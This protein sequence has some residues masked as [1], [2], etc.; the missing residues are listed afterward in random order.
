MRNAVAS[1]DSAQPVF[2]F[3]TMEERVEETW[4]T[5][6]LLTSLLTLFA[7]L[8]CILAVVGI[9]GVISYNGLRR[10]R[11]IGVRLALGARRQQI[12]TLI[13]GQGLRLLLIGLFVGFA[14]AFALS[15]VMRSVLFGVSATD[16][17][18]FFVVSLILGCAAILACWIPA[19][20]ASRT[21]PM[22]TLRAE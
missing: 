13:L 15:G 19:H 10:T 2:E 8:A 14:A 16:P 20:R 17:F 22:I 3:R 12:V 9:Y 1:L 18:I 11:E 5:P 6:R 21:D 7:A 4:T